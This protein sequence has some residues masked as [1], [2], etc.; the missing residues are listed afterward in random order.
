MDSYEKQPEI[1]RGRLLALNRWN[2]VQGPALE[3]LA[4]AVSSYEYP[5][6]HERKMEALSRAALDQQVAAQTSEVI[7]SAE[8]FT[9]DAAATLDEVSEIVDTA[10]EA[11]KAQQLA[12]SA[13]QAAKEAHEHAPQPSAEQ[14][15]L[16]ETQRIVDNAPG[17]N[18]ID[19][20]MG[21]TPQVSVDA[22]NAYTGMGQ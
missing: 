13:R 20:A 15:V 7:A 22:V 11:E 12:L 5:G 18:A 8:Q 4:E 9:A 6:H 16:E 3:N 19:Q 17:A 1:D 14:A 21:S 2:L 10:A